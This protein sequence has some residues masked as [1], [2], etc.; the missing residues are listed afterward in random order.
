MKNDV[1]HIDDMAQE[2]LSVEMILQQGHLEHLN[3]RYAIIVEY[4]GTSFFGSQCQPGKRTVQ[5]E[6]EAALSILLKNSVKAVFS[7]RTDTGVHSRG[8]VVHFDAP[9]KVDTRKF[10]NSLNALLPEDISI[11]AMS[12]VD[13]QFHAQKSATY[14]W[15]RYRINNN[16]QRSVWNSETVHFRPTLNVSAMQKALKYLEGKH[17]F[18]GFRNSKTSTVNT[19][20]HMYKAEC[21]KTDDMITIDLVSNRFLYSMVRIIVGTLLE[22]GKGNKSPEFMLEILQSQDRKIAGQTAPAD[23]LTLMQVGYNKEH[24]LDNLN[25][26]ALKNENFFCKAS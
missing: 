19:I 1:K 21:V 9:H 10:I 17:D 24:N 26:E 3:F 23:G 8:Q 16:S 12:E 2:D 6:L 18:I 15:Y 7:G 5:S 4:I 14:R 25:K 20:C 11:S 22:I 13:R